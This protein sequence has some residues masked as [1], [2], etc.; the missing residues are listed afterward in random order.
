MSIFI[1][2]DVELASSIRKIFQTGDDKY[3]INTA[4]IDRLA[5][6][7]NQSLNDKIKQ[8]TETADHLRIEKDEQQKINEQKEKE[9]ND[10]KQAHENKITL[11]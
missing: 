2:K 7:M 3:I 10:V 5:K 8:L 11:L 9:I 1:K 4:N 6:Q